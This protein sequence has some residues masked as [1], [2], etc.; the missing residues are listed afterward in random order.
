MILIYGYAKI[1]N[2]V[3]FIE[4]IAIFWTHFIEISSILQLGHR[5]TSQN[6]LKWFVS[7]CRAE[8]TDSYRIHNKL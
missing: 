8:K 5:I 7:C 3:G 1:N 6:S 2:I 4:K